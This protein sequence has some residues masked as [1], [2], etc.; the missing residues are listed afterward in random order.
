MELSATDPEEA[1][2]PPLR[3]VT[4][5]KA[6]ELLAADIRSS[7][8]L[9][10][11]PS[12]TPLLN[13]RE[14]IDAYGL[15][16]S[17]VREAIRILEAE[18]LLRVSR[19]PRGG[20]FVSHPDARHMARMMAILLALEDVPLRS[21][22]GFRKLVEP[23]LAAA[24]AKWSTD[25]ER[26]ELVAAAEATELGRPG[27][28]YD[29]HVRIASLARN[30]VLRIVM[31]ALDVT[32]E[33]HADQEDFPASDLAVAA[34]AHSRLARAIADGDSALAERLML[35]HLEAYEKAMEEKGRLDGPIVPPTYWERSLWAD[36]KTITKHR[37]ESFKKTR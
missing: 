11:L 18:G 21:L 19:G 31:T 22:M 33:L 8:V 29:L 36:G 9:N 32:V 4:L 34:K 12:G 28:R 24:A 1:P 2:R 5:P 20:I 3:G 26:A 30:Q 14:I 6:G 23:Q 10:R 35:R 27:A 25:E 37:T 16:R 15:S 13:E 17:S 7:V